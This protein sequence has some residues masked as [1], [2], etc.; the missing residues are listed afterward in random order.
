MGA[1]DA[2]HL[3][4]IKPEH[5]GSLSYNYKNLFSVVLLAI[6]DSNYRLLYTDVGSFGKD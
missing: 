6:A 3:R 1:I 5:S 4:I 2:N